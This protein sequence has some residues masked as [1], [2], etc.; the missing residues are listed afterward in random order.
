MWGQLASEF[1]FFLGY[2]PSILAPREIPQKQRSGDLEGRGD[3]MGFIKSRVVIS[4]HI[5]TLLHLLLPQIHSGTWQ[6]LRSPARSFKKKASSLGTYVL[7]MG[8]I[9]CLYFV[10]FLWGQE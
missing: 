7:A 10:G 5:D 6:V 2:F 3:G 8:K 4:L 1:S 9:T